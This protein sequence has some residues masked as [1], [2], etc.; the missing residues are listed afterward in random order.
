MREVTT[1]KVVYECQPELD[2]IYSKAWDAYFAT[3]DPIERE[4][5]CKEAG[6]AQAKLILAEIDMDLEL[7]FGKLSTY[8]K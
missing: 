4:K 7:E 3:K 8:G 5:I 1:T 2:E 6:E